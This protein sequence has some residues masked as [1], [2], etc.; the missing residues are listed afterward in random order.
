MEEN[1]LISMVDYVLN[2]TNGIFE[3]NG[4]SLPLRSG[5]LYECMEYA[6]FLKKELQLGFFVPTDKEGNVLEK[7]EDA[8]YPTESSRERNFEHYK[9]VY[10]E[11]LGRVI[12]KGFEFQ[13]EDED[14]TYLKFDL[15]GD[16]HQLALSKWD[17]CFRIFGDNWNN[18]I[19]ETIEDLVGL[20]LTLI[21]H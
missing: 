16:D 1:K 21:K 10:Q 18:D 7:P 17:D 5:A 3:M 2:K 19:L 8:V 20:D 9:G 13:E 6:N 14:M 11:A 15:F 4:L 12:F